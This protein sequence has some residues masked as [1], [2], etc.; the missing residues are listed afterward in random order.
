MVKIVLGVIAGFIAW[1]IMWIGSDQVLINTIDWY[2]VHQLAFEKAMINKEPFTA[3]MTVLLM[4]IGRAVI[5][6]LLA[7]FLAAVVANENRYST[8]VLGILL[9][10]FGAMVEVIAWNYLPVWYH[11]VF[12]VLLIPVTVIGGKLRTVTSA[13]SG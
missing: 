4:N 2:G 6:S 8:L 9:I 10:A 1:S 3:S 13:S 11:V 7:G 12:L 5:I